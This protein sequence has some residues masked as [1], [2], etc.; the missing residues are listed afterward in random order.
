[1]KVLSLLHDNPTK[2]LADLL[3]EG[4]DAALL[5][6]WHA[7]EHDKFNL[8]SLTVRIDKLQVKPLL[9]YIPQV[10]TWEDSHLVTAALNEW[11]A[12]AFDRNAMG[13]KAAQ[14]AV[15][16]LREA[17]PHLFGPGFATD[18]RVSLVTSAQ[19]LPHDVVIQ[20]LRPVVKGR[21]TRRAQSVLL[22][23][24]GVILL[25]QSDTG[26]SLAT[27]DALAEHTNDKVR[28]A[29]L[30]MHAAMAKFLEVASGQVPDEEIAGVLP[31]CV[32]SEMLICG[33][34][35]VL[36]EAARQEPS[37]NA[38]ASIIESSVNTLVE[39]G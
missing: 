21:L 17:M 33:P 5:Q 25:P 32:E 13:S 35:S 30:A 27:S 15:E 11:A 24:P 31:D 2:W 4:N 8:A 38:L 29:Y 10:T 9:G 36:I 23:T 1:M 39:I 6:A 22:D 3:F 14:L 28:K 19:D 18:K 37:L 20:M 12:V 7:K 26:P 16:V 34:A